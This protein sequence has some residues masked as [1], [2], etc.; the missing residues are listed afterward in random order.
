MK[1]VLLAA[2][3][4]LLLLAPAAVADPIPPPPDAGDLMAA[5][6]KA[7]HDDAQAI[8]SQAQNATAWVR[9]AVNGTAGNV[10]HIF[11]STSVRTICSLPDF[12][13]CTT[14]VQYVRS[15]DPGH[16]VPF[17]EKVH[18]EDQTATVS[19][20]GVGTFNAHPEVGTWTDLVRVV[21]QV[22]C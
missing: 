9:E 17:Y 18:P 16:V 12:S 5:L 4:C 6:L 2:T 14:C 10:T 22:Q 11:V 21:R 13:R 1:S 20:A 15:F 19:Y 3:L 8:M 7:A